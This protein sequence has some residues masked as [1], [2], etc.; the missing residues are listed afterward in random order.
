M[1]ILNAGYRNCICPTNLRDLGAVQS[2]TEEPD[3]PASLE[4][5]EAAHTLMTANNIIFPENIA[6]AINVYISLVSLIESDIDY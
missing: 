4:F 1:V 6:D 5:L 3:P 2:Y